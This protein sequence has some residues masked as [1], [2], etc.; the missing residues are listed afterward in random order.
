M[1]KATT[2]SGHVEVVALRGDT[3][4]IAND[5]TSVQYGCS[6]PVGTNSNLHS[7]SSENDEEEIE[8]PFME[9]KAKKDTLFLFTFGLHASRTVI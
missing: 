6:G 9:V 4:F 1:G 3:D 7:I 2:N 5:R 8:S